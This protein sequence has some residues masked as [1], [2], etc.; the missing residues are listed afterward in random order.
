MC[1]NIYGKH[2]ESNRVPVHDRYVCR[3]LIAQRFRLPCR[4]GDVKVRREVLR[5][6]PDRTS[7][8]PELPREVDV[9]RRV[10]E[11]EGVDRVLRDEGVGTF[12][13]TPRERSGLDDGGVMLRVAADVLLLD[14][15]DEVVVRV[16]SL[17][18]LRCLEF[19]EDLLTPEEDLLTPEEDLLTPEEDLLTPEEDLLTPEEDLLTPEEDLLTP[20]E[21]LLTPEE[22]LLTPEEDLLTPEEDLLTPLLV[23]PLRR[24]VVCRWVI[25]LNWRL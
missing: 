12:D 4:R 9:A 16:P 13:R 2:P 11:E 1:T 22:D 14:L 23:F 17:R 18:A 15:G 10:G 5:L 20:E 3:I 21:D 25:G 6:L 7:S 24:T 8:P 19:A